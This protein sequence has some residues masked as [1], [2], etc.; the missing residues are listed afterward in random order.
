MKFKHKV[1]GIIEDVANPSL[2]PQYLKHSDVY[3]RIEDKPTG[4]QKKPAEGK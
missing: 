2:I 1:T 4:K 3:E